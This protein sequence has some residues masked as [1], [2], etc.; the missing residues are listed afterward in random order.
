MI[1]AFVIAGLLISI[2]AIWG[3]WLVLHQERLL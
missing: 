1:S 2:M 3:I